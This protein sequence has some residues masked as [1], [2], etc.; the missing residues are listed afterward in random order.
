M[1][2]DGLWTIDELSA[3]V[4]EALT[5]DYPG[6]A[7][8]RVR[9]VPDRRTIRWY[10]TIGLLDRPAAMRGRTALYSRR[11]LLQIVA[12]KRL[13]AVG[14]TLAEVQRQLVGATAAML[15]DIAR[16]PDG[17]PSPPPAPRPAPARAKFWADA[18]AAPVAPTDPG[19]V[20]VPGIRLGTGATLL[21]GAATHAPDTEELAAIEAAARPLLET[22]R[23]LGLD[24]SADR[25]G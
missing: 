17:A 23:R 8:G 1:P 16:L 15:E 5:A 18:P 4:A 20:V 12:I 24:L 9:E 11:H 19:P 10:T 14:N 21:L 2:D 25:E 6:Q 22:L 7:N 13:Q 3:G